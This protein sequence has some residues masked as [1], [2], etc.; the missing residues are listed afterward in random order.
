MSC[1]AS[2]ISMRTIVNISGLG[3]TNSF[4][5]VKARRAW[6]AEI[7]K[8]AQKEFDMGD[9]EQEVFDDFISKLDHEIDYED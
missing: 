6:I 1:N 7:R 3:P 9:V 4:S 2:M 8:D 5:Y